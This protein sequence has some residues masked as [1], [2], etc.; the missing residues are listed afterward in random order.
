MTI[1]I[2]VTDPEC[3]IILAM[4]LSHF[5]TKVFRT[6]LLWESLH[7]LVH[8]MR[9]SSFLSLDL[10]GGHNKIDIETQHETQMV[11]ELLATP[12]T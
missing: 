1:S 10:Q 7:S 8:H 11:R 4:S 5:S 3:D 2:M 12:Y 9:R 6:K